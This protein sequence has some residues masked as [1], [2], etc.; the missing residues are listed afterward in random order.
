MSVLFI[1]EI[2]TGHPKWAKQVIPKKGNENNSDSD[3]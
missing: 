3:S 1:Q 2:L